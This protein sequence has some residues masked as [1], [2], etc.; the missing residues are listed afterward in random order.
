M[1][2][3]RFIVS[4]FPMGPRAAARYANRIERRYGTNIRDSEVTYSE[5]AKKRR[6]KSGLFSVRG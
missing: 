3:S 1:G 4:A 5:P 2:I 6:K